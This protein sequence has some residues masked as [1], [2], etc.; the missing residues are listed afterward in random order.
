MSQ[1]FGLVTVMENTKIYIFHGTDNLNFIKEGLGDYIKSGKIILLNLNKDNITREYYS[2]LLTSKDFWY[3]INGE[4]I[5]I[6]Q[7]DS[8][9]CKYPKYPITH[10]LKYGYIGGPLE[11]SDDNNSIINHVYHFHLFFHAKPIQL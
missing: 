2:N 3:K 9:I 6:F 1:N 11:K 7:T 10:F 8:C 4:N 5:L